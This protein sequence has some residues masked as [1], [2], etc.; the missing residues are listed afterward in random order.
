MAETG[1]T[2]EVILKAKPHFNYVF[3][4][5][6]EQECIDI[7]ERMEK[8]NEPGELERFKKDY[9]FDILNIEAIGNIEEATETPDVLN[10]FIDE[11]DTYGPHGNGVWCPTG[12]I[13]DTKTGEVREDDGTKLYN[14]E[15]RLM[16]SKILT[17]KE[18]FM[19]KLGRFK[20]S[21]HGC[22]FRR[23]HTA[24]QSLRTL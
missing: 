11:T 12:R 8:K 24:V 17:G 6:T 23:G 22:I 2:L 4:S 7:K 1:E 15:V 14:T 5:M 9:G 13:K 16:S 3:K 20:D 19:L 21:T 10:R 18:A